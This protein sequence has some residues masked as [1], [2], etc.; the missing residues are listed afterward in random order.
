M[1]KI[2]NKYKSM[3]VTVKATFWF[4]VCSFLQRGISF[5]TTPI[6]TR[7]LTTS[8]FGEFSVFQ[9]W[10]SILTV[11]VTLN[12]PWGV[13]PQGL[14]KFEEQKNRFASA[15]QSLLLLLVVIWFA[16]Y[17]PFR[18]YINNLI[19]LDTPKMVALFILMWTS[20]VF[21]FW[22]AYERTD[23]KYK[24]LVI[25]TLIVSVL[26]PAIGIFLIKS[27]SDKVLARIWGLVIVEFICYVFLFIKQE[28]NGKTFYDW[29]IWKYALKYNIVLIP[30]Y[31]SQT[32]LS[33]ADRIMIEK[34]VSYDK[35]GIYTLAYSLSLLML[36]FNSSVEQAINPWIFKQIKNNNILNIKSI[37]YP[38]I[39]AVAVLNLLLM[40][41]APEIVLIFAPIE[42]FEAIWIIPPVSMS[43]FF[44]FLYDMFSNI[45]FYYEKTKFMSVAT[46]LGAILNIILNYIFIKQFGYY[47]A[48]YTTLFCYI[49]Y[50]VAHY[51]VMRLICLKNKEQPFELKFVLLTTLF[52]VGMGFIIL[53]TYNTHIIRYSLFGICFI[54]VCIYRKKIMDYF[55]TIIKINRQ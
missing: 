31:L 22:S 28:K 43:V 19:G 24:K 17:F 30:H 11:I 48:G 29:S 32:V 52:F 1:K 6:F 33:G 7:L 5:I 12:L 42:Y 41:F 51:L 16:I 55:K 38:A 2:I 34:M 10:L 3:P 50:A 4:L 9:T 45:E 49:C 23:L 46:V 36:I 37:V 18:T 54:V 13:Y 15:L 21:Y 40:I 26:K 35:A 14:V 25:L 47:A 53:L 44:M 39:I 20:S 8:Q 27:Y